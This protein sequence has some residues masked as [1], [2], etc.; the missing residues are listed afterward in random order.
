[1]VVMRRIVDENWQIKYPPYLSPAAKVRRR[2]AVR[3]S[4]PAPAAAPRGV[5]HRSPPAH[6]PRRPAPARSSPLLLFLMPPPLPPHP[7]PSLQDLIQRLL[8][9]KPAKRLGMLS[10]KAMDV[11]RH[12]W[13]EGVDWEALAAKRVAPVRKP[14][15]RGWGDGGL[16]GG[17]HCP[18]RAATGV[19]VRRVAA[20]LGGGQPPLA[21]HACAYMPARGHACTAPLSPPAR[22]PT[23]PSASRSW[24]RMRRRRQAAAARRRQR[25][26]QSARPCSATSERGGRACGSL[27]ARPGLRLA[28]PGLVSPLATRPAFLSRRCAGPA[29]LAPFP[30]AALPGTPL[31]APLPP[32]LHFKGPRGRA[33]P[34]LFPARWPAGGAA[35]ADPLRALAQR[36]RPG[37]AAAAPH[38][39][40]PGP[41]SSNAVVPWRRGAA[42]RAAP[43]PPRPAGPRSMHAP[44]PGNRS[45]R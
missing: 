25:S 1:M 14:R 5:R 43:A 30:I 41:G 6:A 45:P 24:W 36:C 18:G 12:K 17:Q 32:S 20:S 40:F 34:S 11:M 2:R 9:R 19:H 38:A 23:A 8:E 4:S 44:T 37:S 35:C 29:R 26:W 39:H 22:S 28:R 21:R 10:G 27:L 16:G 33:R 7:P 3:S 42:A 13:F 15:V 31:P